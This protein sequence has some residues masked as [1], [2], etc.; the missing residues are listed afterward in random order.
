LSGEFALDIPMG[1]SVSFETE[2]A[3]RMREISRQALKTH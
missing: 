2:G 3:V 1:E